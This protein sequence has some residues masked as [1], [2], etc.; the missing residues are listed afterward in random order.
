MGKASAK[1]RRLNNSSGAEITDLAIAGAATIYSETIPIGDNV[2]FS[3]I[4]AK[5][6][7]SGGAGSVAISAEYSIDAIT[8]HTP[9]TTSGGTLTADSNIVTAL[10]N[11]ERY[12]PF[13]ARLGVYMRFKI[14]ASTASQLTMDLIYQKFN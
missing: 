5:E 9:Y 8:F 1:H 12:I 7:K 13:T 6:N 3:T 10:A 11:I 4:L 2:G 14:V